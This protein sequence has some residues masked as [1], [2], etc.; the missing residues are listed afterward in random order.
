MA[1]TY[2]QRLKVAILCSIVF[3]LGALGLATLREP[4]FGLGGVDRPEPIVLNLQQEKPPEARRRLVD[5]QTPAEEVPQ[6]TDLISDVNSEAMDTQ[7][8]PGEDEG[9]HFETPDEFDT[10]ATTAAVSQEPPEPKPVTEPVEKREAVQEEDTQP[11]PAPAERPEIPLPAPPPPQAEAEINPPA[12]EP[13]MERIQ[14]AQAMVPAKPEALDRRAKGRQK[15]GVQKQGITN[16][17]AIEDDI[18]PYLQEVRNRVEREWHGMLLV[19]YSGT[20]PTA[21]TIDCEISADGR[22][23]SV[24]IRDDPEDRIY[25]SLCKAAV[26]KAGP[27][28]PFPFVVPD[29]YRNRNLEIRWTFRY[30]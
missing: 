28:K 10:L 21:V 14:V 15:K 3:H 19:R 11:I 20:Q 24:E 17:S 16:F 30:L 9:P 23:V 7:L 29:I 12:P 22:L 18:A 25:A 8:R 2:S 26:R 6:D 4:S 13:D 1:M 5:T 27:F